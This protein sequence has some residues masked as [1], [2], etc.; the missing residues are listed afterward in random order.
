MWGERW[1]GCSTNMCHNSSSPFVYHCMSIR[2]GWLCRRT[3]LAAGGGGCTGV[4]IFTT[5]LVARFRVWYIVYIISNIV[6]RAL[7]SPPHPNL[8]YVDFHIPQ[9]NPSL[10]NPTQSYPSLISTSQPNRSITLPTLP[11]LT[12]P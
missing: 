12:H 1:W 2:W 11:L 6:Y 7:P 3:S 4:S 5:V 10:T 8:I 9:T